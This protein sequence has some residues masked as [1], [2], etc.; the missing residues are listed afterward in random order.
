MIVPPKHLN[1][2]CKFDKPVT[3]TVKDLMFA[4]IDSLQALAS[5]EIQ[6]KALNDFYEQQRKNYERSD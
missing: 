3:E 4:Y 1:K 5:C 2:E 6:R